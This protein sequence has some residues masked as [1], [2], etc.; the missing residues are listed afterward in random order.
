MVPMT[1]SYDAASG[2]GIA[3]FVRLI[4]SFV[5]LIASFFRYFSSG[6]PLIGIAVGIPIVVLTIFVVRRARRARTAK[7]VAGRDND[8]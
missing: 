8:D 2:E 4:F 5:R 3:E 7:R 1:Q 6:H